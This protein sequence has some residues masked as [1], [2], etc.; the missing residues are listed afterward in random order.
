MENAIHDLSYQSYSFAKS[1]ALELHEAASDLPEKIAA[2]ARNGTIRGVV[3][4]VEE[5]TK[6]TQMVLGNAAVLVVKQVGK[7]G[8]KIKEGF[9]DGYYKAEEKFWEVAEEMMCWA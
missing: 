9:K 5:A 4:A 1:V 3:D 6:S 8:G 2:D 7:G